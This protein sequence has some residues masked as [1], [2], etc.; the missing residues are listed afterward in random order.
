[1]HFFIILIFSFL[2]TPRIAHFVRF[3]SSIY[4]GIRS[5]IYL[6]IFLSFYFFFFFLSPGSALFPFSSSLSFPRS[7]VA[8]QGLVIPMV[9]LWLPPSC[10]RVP[11]TRCARRSF[12]RSPSGRTRGFSY[13]SPL[14][15]LS[16]LRSRSSSPRFPSQWASPPT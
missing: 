9:P 5:E 11:S 6:N 15:G 12:P 10:S 4:E 7:E 2:F 14:L 3:G 16:S 1:V 8:P 13:S